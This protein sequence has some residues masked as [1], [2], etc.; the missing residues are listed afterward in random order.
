M[1]S[2]LSQCNAQYGRLWSFVLTECLVNSNS[3]FTSK[4][5]LLMNQLCSNWTRTTNDHWL[6]AWCFCYMSKIQKTIVHCRHYQKV[7][8]NVAHTNHS[9]K[10]I[11]GIWCHQFNKKIIKTIMNFS[12]LLT[13]SQSSVTI[14]TK[15]SMKFQALS[16]LKIS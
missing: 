2:T 1:A 14:Q 7:Y 15:L 13:L 3:F 9:R 8:H 5:F 10:Y 4:Y 12:I 11:P 6:K 16:H